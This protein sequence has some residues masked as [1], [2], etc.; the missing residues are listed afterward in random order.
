[1]A[2]NAS[3]LLAQLSKK[4]PDAVKVIQKYPAS[5]KLLNSTVD[6]ANRKGLTLIYGGIGTQSLYPYAQGVNFYSSQLA[7]YQSPPERVAN[8]FL[9]EMQNAMRAPEYAK[10]V[11]RAQNEAGFSSN[12]YVYLILE[13]ETRGALPVG[14]MWNDIVAASG[15]T[16]ESKSAYYRGLYLEFLQ[17]KQQVGE[18]AALTATI[19]KVRYTQYEDGSGDTRETRYNRNHEQYRKQAGQ[20]IAS[21]TYPLV[22]RV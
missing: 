5:L 10:V 9:F 21:A 2:T 14:S 13:F 15:I 8:Y 11:Y 17:K 6:E 1:M 12:S 18:S 20:P 3:E 16:L 7:A 19:Q 4:F 22:G